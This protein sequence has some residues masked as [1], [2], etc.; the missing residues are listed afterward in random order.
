MGYQNSTFPLAIYGC[1]DTCSRKLLWLKVWDS[2]SK[3]EVVG[4]WYLE[5]LYEN[6][7]LPAFLHID[8]GTETVIMS[9]MH[10]YLRS[11]HS[12][13]DDATDSVV[14]G[15]STSNQVFRIVL[16]HLFFLRNTLLR[17]T[18]LKMPKT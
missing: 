17:N 8:K 1:I 9:T 4:K 14:F 10:C 2:N 15:P 18:R 16:H 6:R 11:N 7:V 3:P 13:L 12:D 5:F